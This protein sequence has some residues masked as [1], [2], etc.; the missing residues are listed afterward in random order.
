[1]PNRVITSTNIIKSMLVIF[2]I[3]FLLDIF[4]LT[5]LKPFW[6]DAVLKIQK[7]PLRINYTYGFIAYLFLVF[8]LYYI[9]YRYVNKTSW[10]KDT[11]IQGFMYGFFVYG[12]F[13]FTNLALFND[14]P[15]GLALVDTVWGGVLMALTSFITYYLIEIKQII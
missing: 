11:L 9:I 14:Y 8:G 13:D 15:L 10:K 7:K 12:T 3:M 4:V 2:V 1:M 5:L 6:G